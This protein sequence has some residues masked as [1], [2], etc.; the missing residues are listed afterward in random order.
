MQYL[1]EFAR[2]LYLFQCETLILWIHKS[3]LGKN[4][5]FSWSALLNDVVVC[6][7]ELARPR[8]CTLLNSAGRNQN[9]RDDD[10]HEVVLD[11]LFTNEDDGQLDAEFDQ[12][13]SG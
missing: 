2:C 6:V 3:H 11:E 8:I 5:R 7:S 1:C 13:S 4:T 10:L 12:T 9:L